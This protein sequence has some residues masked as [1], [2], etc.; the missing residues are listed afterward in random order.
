MN[1]VLCPELMYH[2]IPVYSRLRVDKEQGSQCWVEGWDLSANK[3]FIQDN[4][5][6]SSVNIKLT[7]LQKLM[8]STLF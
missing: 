3:T 1:I 6:L 7:I 4:G 8:Y 5:F 2:H